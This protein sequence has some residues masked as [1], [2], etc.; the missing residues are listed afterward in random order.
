MV[1]IEKLLL[2]SAILALGAC[3]PPEPTNVPVGDVLVRQIT[4]TGSGATVPEGRLNLFVIIPVKARPFDERLEIVKAYLAQE[5]NCVLGTN[6]KAR[7]ES[8]T[9]GGEGNSQKSILA[10]LKC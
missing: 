2:T 6:N 4:G 10:P 1:T 5:G 7:I 8:L 3:G 9:R